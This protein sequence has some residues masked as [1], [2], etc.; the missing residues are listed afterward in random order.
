MCCNP[1]SFHGRDARA[2][3]GPAALGVGN[4]YRT[5]LPADLRSSLEIHN[6]PRDESRCHEFTGEGM[7]LDTR[8]IADRWK[9]V[10]EIHETERF[11]WRLARGHGGRRVA[12]RSPT[13]RATCCASTWTPTW[14]TRSERLSSTCTTARLGGGSAAASANGFLSVADRLDLGRF[15]IDQYGY[16]QL[17]DEALPQ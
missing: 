15:R 12:S 11:F 17:E 1:C 7:L 2:R 6:G 16:L 10:T 9:M 8:E 13:T 14:E 5:T 4:G 3:Y